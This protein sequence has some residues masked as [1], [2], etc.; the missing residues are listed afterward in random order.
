M[1]SS[2]KESKPALRIVVLEGSPLGTP[3]AKGFETIEAAEALVIERVRASVSPALRDRLETALTDRIVS[4]DGVKAV[5][6]VLTSKLEFL[7]ALT[8][9]YA[10][11][12]TITS[13]SVNEVDDER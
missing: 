10:A 12:I 6:E 7:R 4:E 2:D 1:T 8:K 5:A 9:A 3:T 13:P 11:K